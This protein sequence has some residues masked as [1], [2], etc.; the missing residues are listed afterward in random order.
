VDRIFSG[1]PSNCPVAGCRKTLR[2]NKFRKQTFEDIGVEREVDIR[3]RVMQM[4]APSHPK[5]LSEFLTNIH[6]LQS[7][8]PR[9]RI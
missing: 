5:Y 9:R 4:Y 3:R 6:T 2:K 8:P 1:G 7:E